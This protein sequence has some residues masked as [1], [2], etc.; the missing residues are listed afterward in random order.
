MQRQPPEATAEMD[1]APGTF[2]DPAEMAGPS[3]RSREDRE[4]SIP[5]N[6][7]PTNLIPANS[8]NPADLIPANLAL[9]DGLW[10]GMRGT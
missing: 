9:A 1:G 10:T 7:I 6:L 2:H 5:T 3:A 8:T 4:D